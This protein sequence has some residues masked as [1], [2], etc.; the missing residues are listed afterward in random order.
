MKTPPWQHRIKKKLQ[1]K[2]EAEDMCELY[3]RD[4]KAVVSRRRRQRKPPLDISMDPK[5]LEEEKTMRDSTLLGSQGNEEKLNERQSRSMSLGQSIS[6]TAEQWFS[7]SGDGLCEG[8]PLLEHMEFGTCSGED[9][10]NGKTLGMQPSEDKFCSIQDQSDTCSS[11]VDLNLPTPP[12]RVNQ[13][14]QRNCTEQSKSKS[15]CMQFEKS[16]S[17]TRKNVSVGGNVADSNSFLKDGTDIGCDF[18]LDESYGQDPGNDIRRYPNT[19]ECNQPC[20]GTEKTKFVN[21]LNSSIMPCSEIKIGKIELVEND[22]TSE[23]FFQNDDHLENQYGSAVW[24]IFRRQDVPKLMEYL[25]KHHKEF[26]HIN[27]LPVNSVS[28]A[29]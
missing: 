27:N 19:S 20:V 15:S 18:P 9:Y 10:E 13:E 11:L 23:N 17:C 28:V 2:Y 26:R 6:D 29:A 1:K 14:H 22:I 16:P 5:I 21:G 7:S 25:K 3:G 4:N 8:V 24:D 12:V